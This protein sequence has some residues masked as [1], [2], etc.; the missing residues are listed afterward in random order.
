MRS[1]RQY[2]LPMSDP[3]TLR[4]ADA[5]RERAVS[6]LREHMVA[7]RLTA[8]EFEQRLGAVHG[9]STQADLDAVKADLPMS[10]AVLAQAHA[11]RKAHL[12]RRLMQEA[13]GASGAWLISIVVWVAIGASGDFWPIWVILA[14]SLPVVRDAWRILGP[15]PDLEAVEANLNA[16]REHR[17][18]RERAREHQL[19]H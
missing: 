13:G 18:A 4:V 16:R 14:T 12:R 6:E 8:E 9:A 2:L 3:S 15:A 17:L 1:A 7:G 19:P 11:E 5:D 10:P